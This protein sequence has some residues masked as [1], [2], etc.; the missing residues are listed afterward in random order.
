MVK[1]SIYDGLSIY[2]QSSDP[3][4]R[5][6]AIEIIEFLK[7]DRNIILVIIL[8]FQ[9]LNI[10]RKLNSLKDKRCSIKIKMNNI[11]LIR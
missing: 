7:E 6:Y 10:L 9:K 2:A 5:A 1:S 11:N 8:I 4:A 3:Q